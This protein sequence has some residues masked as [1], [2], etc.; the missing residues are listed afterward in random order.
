MGRQ[1]GPDGQAACGDDPEAPPG[2]VCRF[3]GPGHHRLGGAVALGG[4][5]ST[6]GVLHGGPVFGHLSGQ[7]EEC[8]QDVEGLEAGHHA[9][10]AE[11][12]R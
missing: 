10:G 1:L 4:D 8:L 11:L 3:E 7:Q 5:G 2:P 9:A 6:V 12:R